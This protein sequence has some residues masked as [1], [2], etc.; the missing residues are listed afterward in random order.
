MPIMGYAAH[1]SSY[2]RALKKSRATPKE[3]I[4]GSRQFEN[5]PSIIPNYLQRGT[6][7]SLSG[8][9]SALVPVGQWTA[10]SKSSTCAYFCGIAPGRILEGS[11]VKCCTEWSGVEME[12]SEAPP[13]N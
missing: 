13:L 11:G 1:A 3:D 5:L 8:G 9:W 12:Q 6:Y 10:V 7:R 2:P 4:I